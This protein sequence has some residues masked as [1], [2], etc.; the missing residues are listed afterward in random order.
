MHGMWGSSF[1]W[2][3]VLAELDAHGLRGIAFDLPGFGLAERPAD[4]DYSWSG[5]G[6]FAV[7][8]VDALGLERYHLVV[9]DIGGP[10][11]FELAAALPER[12]ASLTI[13]NTM[14]DVTEFVPPWTMRPFRRPLV[15]RLW[16]AGMR[17][18]L[19]RLLTRLQGVG[20]MSSVSKPELDTYLR[21]VK[22]GDGGRAFLKAMRSTERTPDKQRLYRSTVRDVPYPVQVVWAAEDP[23]LKLR[24]YGEKARAAA[25]LDTIA[26][27]PGKHFFQE[28]QA[29]AIADRVATIAAGAAAHVAT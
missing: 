20:D 8:A 22:E 1:L 4:Y 7:A 17:P 3:K 15:G 29:A 19:F 18:L 24:V 13:L 12:V 27:L 6:R 5:L 9:H 23:A 16:M 2:R 10:V 28:D 14:I 11:G 26:E 25:N 21:L